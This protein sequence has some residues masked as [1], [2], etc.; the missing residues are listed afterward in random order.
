[1][2]KIYISS[3]S[4]SKIMT[5]RPLGLTIICI[6]GF[7]GAVLTIISGIEMLFALGTTFSGETGGISDNVSG[8]TGSIIG[9]VALLISIVSFYAFYGLWNIKKWAWT[10]TVILEII[11]IIFDLIS[12]NLAIIIP[13]IVVIYLWMKRGIFSA[14]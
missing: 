9:I 14:K 5:E 1:M 8:V 2:K 3:E 4:Y 7:V 10:L 11:N 13:V 12:L 6:F